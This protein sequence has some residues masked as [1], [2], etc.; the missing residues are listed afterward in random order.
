MNILSSRYIVD[1]FIY[2]VLILP[3][4]NWYIQLVLSCFIKFL[5]DDSPV[6]RYACEPHGSPG[7]GRMKLYATGRKKMPPKPR[8]HP[9]T[10]TPFELIDITGNI[11]VCAGCGFPKSRNVV[12]GPED[13]EVSPFDQGLCVRHKENDYAPVP[14]RGIYLAT[15]SNK[16]YHVNAT[17]ILGRN[18]HFVSDNLHITIGRERLTHALRDFLKNRLNY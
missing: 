4:F 14:S 8:V 12:D 1:P 15:F 16:H 9:T 5:S 3:I 11:R 18:P 17:C 7:N 6:T 10:N 13:Q 2:R